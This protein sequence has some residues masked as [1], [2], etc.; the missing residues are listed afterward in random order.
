MS[1]LVPP[2]PLSGGMYPAVLSPP[3]STSPGLS[4]LYPVVRYTGGAIK[5]LLSPAPSPVVP[6]NLLTTWGG[7]S[8]AAGIILAALAAAASASSSPSGTK[9]AIRALRA[10]TRK[11]TPITGSRVQLSCACTRT[12]GFGGQRNTTG[13]SLS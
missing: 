4:G 10:K 8:P 3:P 2:P 12:L 7:A 11:R 6:N 9:V 1:L 5:R 13:L